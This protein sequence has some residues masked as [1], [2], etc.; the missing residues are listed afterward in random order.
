MRARRLFMSSLLALLVLESAVVHLGFRW[1]D[2]PARLEDFNWRR[3]SEAPE[4]VVLG[5]CLSVGLHPRFLESELGGTA[6]V[7]N[8]SRGDT[9][10]LNWYLLA[11]NHVLKRPGDRT[12]LMVHHPSELLTPV[13]AS[14]GEAVVLDLASWSDMP[15]VLRMASEPGRSPLHLLLAK[16]WRTYRYRHFMASALWQGLGIQGALPD[17]ASLELRPEAPATRAERQARALN[18][19]KL[20]LDAA[21]EQQTQVF[22]VPLPERN[23]PKAAGED[24]VWQAVAPLGASFLDVREQVPVAPGDFWTSRHMTD[25]GSQKFCRVLAS[26]LKRHLSLGADAASRP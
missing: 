7:Y 15:L 10:A 26:A 11:I 4:V 8:L 2:F 17:E 19:L 21:H 3:A 24:R 22:F 25:Q 18:C 16:I 23:S 6:K 1:D 13:G 20:L 5:T 12:I 14:E 9:Y